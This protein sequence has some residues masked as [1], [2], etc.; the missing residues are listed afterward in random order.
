[1]IFFTE[2]MLNNY[3]EKVIKKNTPEIKKNNQDTLSYKFA[4]L[5]KVNFP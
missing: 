3:I 4:V 2:N 5:K 1:M